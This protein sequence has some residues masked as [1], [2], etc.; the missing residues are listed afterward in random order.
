MPPYTTCIPA[1]VAVSIC[2]GRPCVRYTGHCS[3]GGQYDSMPEPGVG[4][5][6]DDTCI[7]R[8]GPKYGFGETT[9]VCEPGWRPK[10]APTEVMKEQPVDML[11]FADG[12]RRENQPTRAA[13]MRVVAGLNLA[14]LGVAETTADVVAERTLYVEG[15]WKL[16]TASG[17]KA[18]WMKWEGFRLDEQT[19]IPG[20]DF[21][22]PTHTMCMCDADLDC[23]VARNWI[24]LGRMWV[25]VA[26]HQNYQTVGTPHTR[27]TPRAPPHATRRMHCHCR[28]PPPA[29]CARLTLRRL[30]H[31]AANTI[32]VEGDMFERYTVSAPR[33]AD[34][35]ARHCDADVL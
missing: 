34:H 29:A 1:R 13:T 5:L 21:Y 26:L 23:T 19:L 4:C 8:A 18:P 6:P 24:S 32:G 14:C 22:D 2:G 7:W 16:D 35:T 28:P 25:E 33:R 27:H 10:F 3:P 17:S 20:T 11:F 30:H 9:S 31:L 12:L 15:E